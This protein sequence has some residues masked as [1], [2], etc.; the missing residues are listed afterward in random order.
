M[1][2]QQAN[3]FRMWVNQHDLIQE[4]I[5]TTAADGNLQ[6]CELAASHGYQFTAAEAITAWG[7]EHGDELPHWDTGE[8]W[9]SWAVWFLGTTRVESTPDSPAND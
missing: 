8:N 2:V 7:T 5:R 9:L 3:D 4:Q 6:L 1:S